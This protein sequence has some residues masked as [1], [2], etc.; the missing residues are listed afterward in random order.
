MSIPQL[1]FLSI[2]LV[3]MMVACVKTK[4]LTLPA[5]LL[6]GGIGVVVFFAAA[7]KGVMLLVTFF[8]LSVLATAHKKG[9][10]AKYHPESLQPG[11]RTAAQ[12]FANGGV[13]AI[14]AVLIILYPL[15]K[16]LFMF[17]MSA[18]L[19]S[20]LADTLSS[21]LG[22]VYGRRFYNILTLKKEQNGLDGVV[23][24]EGTLFG[25]AGACLVGFAFF[26]FGKAGLIVA[27]A[28]VLG[29]LMDSV[30]GAALERKHQIGNNAVNFINT[31][32]AAVVALLIFQVLG[33]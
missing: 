2:L 14:L 3:A 23:S 21:E 6:A 16:E 9:S 15:H 29:N 30:L 8:V 32:F 28:G 27:I 24:A 17:M 4:K 7:F 22:M 10:K 25:T 19:A 18:S 26:G 11:G 13:A 5:A 31:L 33:F 12:V 1:L 20:A